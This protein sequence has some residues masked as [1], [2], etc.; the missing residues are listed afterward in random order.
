MV[1][2]QTIEQ[3]QEE[4]KETN[5]NSSTD[6]IDKAKEQADRLEAANKKQE[7]LLDRQEQILAKQAL[8]G[9]SEAGQRT[10]EQVKLSDE[11]YAQK[12][13]NGEANPLMEDGYG[14]HE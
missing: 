7:E 12:V 6:L 1:K 13:M 10:P 8:G 4:V 5:E 2:E 14:K 9:R 3:A 11:E